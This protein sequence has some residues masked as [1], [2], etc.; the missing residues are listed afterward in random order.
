VL[1]RALDDPAIFT[2]TLK[3]L[4]QTIAKTNQAPTG[5]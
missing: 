5:A 2:R 4:K 1:A 3:R